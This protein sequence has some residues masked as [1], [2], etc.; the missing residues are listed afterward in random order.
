[1]KKFKVIMFRLLPNGAHYEF[2]SWVSTKLA[3][4]GAAVKTALGAL[5]TQFNSWLDK[6]KALMA[7][8]R[9]SALTAKIAEADHRLD[10]ALV[11][12]KAQVHALEYS[13]VPADAEAAHRLGIMLRSYGK[14]YNKSYDDQS[15]DIRAIVLQLAGAYEADVLRLHLEPQGAELYAAYNEFRTLLAQRSTDEL[16][17]PDESFAAVRRGIEDV[18]HQIVVK[19][20]A[21]AE[22]DASPDFAAFIDSLNSEIERLNAEFHRARKDLGAGDHTVIEPIET[23]QYTERPVTP[24]PEVHYR[25]EGKE[26]KRL[27]LGEDF[28]VTY[29][30]NT[31]VGMAELTIHGKGE[32]RGAKT[33]TFNIA[34]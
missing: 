6:E 1:M 32:Y 15:G 9:K 7:W 24:V 2:C 29:K 27:Y 18:Y 31:N 19:A 23:Q 25:E 5:I 33:A 34:R 30:N 11:A 14:V 3:A 16:Q 12:L 21:G 10:Q 8:V 26:T 22:L 17:K 28:S 4:A 13:L 20:N